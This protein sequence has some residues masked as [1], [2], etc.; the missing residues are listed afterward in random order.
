MVWNIYEVLVWIWISGS[1]VWFCCNFLWDIKNTHQ[2]SCIS[3]NYDIHIFKLDYRLW[4]W[5]FN[6]E[7][8]F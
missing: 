8:K 5:V 2:P 7:N 1:H 3:S 4:G 6:L